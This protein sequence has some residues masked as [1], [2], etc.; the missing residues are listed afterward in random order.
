MLP[1]MV[2]DVTPGTRLKAAS[3]SKWVF[4]FKVIDPR[5]NES[6]KVLPLELG[7]RNPVLEP[8]QLFP[9]RSQVSQDTINETC[10]PVGKP[11]S[12]ARVTGRVMLAKST[13]NQS[14][15]P[16]AAPEQTPLVLL[17][18]YVR[19]VS[20]RVKGSFAKKFGPAPGGD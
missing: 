10:A 15:N 9:F 5:S 20:F 18:V 19:S 17:Q 4:P 14:K 7:V 12:T 1:G 3:S 6:L 11:P 2:T 13:S 8:P 16:A